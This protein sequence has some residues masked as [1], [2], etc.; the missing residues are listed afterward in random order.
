MIH[1]QFYNYICFKGMSFTNTSPLVVPTRAKKV[2]L[3]VLMIEILCISVSFLNDSTATYIL[4]QFQAILGTNPIS[5]AAPGNHGDSFVLDMATSTAA[6][7]K[8]S[9]GHKPVR[10]LLRDT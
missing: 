3:L 5:L 8:V 1:E 2:G 7:G 6:L 9:L 10:S 4:Y